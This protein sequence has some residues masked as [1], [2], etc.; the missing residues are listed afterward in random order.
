M[1]LGDFEMRICGGEELAGGY[2]GLVHGQ[3]YSIELA[4]HSSRVCDVAL[5]IDGTPCGVFRLNHQ[6]RCTIEH[7]ADDSGCFTFLELATTEARA[8][9]VK[10][11]DETG[12]IAA[13][14]MPEREK[15]VVL[16]Q[17]ASGS[18]APEEEA[19]SPELSA[20]GT[21]LSGKSNQEYGTATRICHAPESEFVTI[22]L[23]LGG[24]K[25][26]EV[27]P[28]KKEPLSSPVP[29]PLS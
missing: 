20:G 16:Y 21:G 7:P 28:L 29:P 17:S 24:R 14:F 13:V 5:S 2:V 8:A 6:R 19:Y 1:K 25:S 12:V 3:R 22:H 27:R 11:N 26:S 18:E 4:N 9:S 23:R 15:P 10:A